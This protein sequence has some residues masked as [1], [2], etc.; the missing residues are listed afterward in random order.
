MKGY[1]EYKMPMAQIKAILKTRKNKE[2]NGSNQ[3]YLCDYVKNNYGILG[4][5][6]RVIGE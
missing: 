6:T 5:V 3:K 1:V 4:T 2:K